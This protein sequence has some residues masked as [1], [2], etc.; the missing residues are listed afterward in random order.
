[1]EHYQ[2]DTYG[3]RIADLYDDWHDRTDTPAT[4]ERLAAV[5]GDGPILELAIGT[6]RVALPLAER[7]LRVHGIDASPAMVERLRSKPG[8]D[9]VTVT[10]GDMADVA[11][12]GPF[13]LVYVVFNSFFALLTQP[14]Q[15]RCFE[16]V[17]RRLAPGGYFV[18]ECFVPEMK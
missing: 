3:E 11:V 4:V 13:S 7:G 9:R 18:V 5:G 8:G 2:Q 14:D 10:I 17:S 1:M 12:D 6:G 16:N 15:V